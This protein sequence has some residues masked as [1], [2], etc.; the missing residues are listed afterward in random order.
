MNNTEVID[1][2]G[3]SLNQAKVQVEEDY[4]SIRSESIRNLFAEVVKVYFQTRQRVH[5]KSTYVGLCRVGRRDLERAKLFGEKL[6]IRGAGVLVIE[7]NVPADLVKETIVSVSLMG[8]LCAP[9]R[10]SDILSDCFHA[11]IRVMM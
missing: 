8:F 6:H 4:K 3:L 5:R 10:L 9:E 2:S 1:L 7:P 11:G